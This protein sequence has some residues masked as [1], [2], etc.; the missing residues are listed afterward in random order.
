[1]GGVGIVAPYQQARRL[2][3]IDLE[4][5]RGQGLDLPLPEGPAD[6]VVPPRS[7]A[8]QPVGDLV[9]QGVAEHEPE[10]RP[11]VHGCPCPICKIY[12]KHPAD[13]H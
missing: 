9:V 12:D 4:P 6:A 10:T 1:M 11:V 2:D 7:P 5:A 13:V 8:G 3:G